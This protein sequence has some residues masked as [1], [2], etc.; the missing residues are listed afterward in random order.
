MLGVLLK[1]WDESTR[2]ENRKAVKEARELRE[3]VTE[4]ENAQAQSE[5][6][7]E[8]LRNQIRRSGQEPDA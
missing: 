7:K 3:R 2:P 4:L 1:K 8:T 5:E 6:D